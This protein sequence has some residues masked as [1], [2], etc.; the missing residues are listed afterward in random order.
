MYRVRYRHGSS[1]N[2]CYRRGPSSSNPR[3]ASNYSLDRNGKE[4]QQR[5][6]PV[7]PALTLM[8][9]NNASVIHRGERT[10]AQGQSMLP[11]NCSSRKTRKISTHRCAGIIAI[12]DH[13]K[14]PVPARDSLCSCWR[15]ISRCRRT[16]S[17]SLRSSEMSLSSRGS[18][19]AADGM[20]LCYLCTLSLM[21]G[22]C[23]PPDETDG[24]QTSMVLVYSSRMY[25]A[26]NRCHL[27]NRNKD[28]HRQTH[29]ASDERGTSLRIPG[30]RLPCQTASPSLG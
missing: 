7:S 24:Q 10:A 6:A 8:T 15:A 2:C 29:Y 13:R 20:V 27:S 21:V 26:Q 19:E 3:G 9:I 5:L 11:S 25:A 18:V 16:S 1:T 12:G 17:C 22:A 14:L 30:L 23:V 4:A 28:P